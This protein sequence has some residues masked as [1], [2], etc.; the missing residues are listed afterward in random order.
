[1]L[2][3]GVH[4]PRRGPSD[5]EIKLVPQLDA[6]GLLRIFY[7]QWPIIGFLMGAGFVLG[8]VYT[9]LATPRYT[10]TVLLFVDPHKPQFNAKQ[11]VSVNGPSDPGLIESQ[12][13]ILKSDSVLKA[14]AH[15][16]DLAHDPAFHPPPGLMSSLISVVTNW[17]RQAPPLSL[18]EIE[19]EIAQQIGSGLKVKRVGLTYVIQID[20][21]STGRELSARIA[22][23]VAD[24]YSLAE[25]DAQYRSNRQ[26]SKWL[27]DRIKELRAQAAD[28]DRAVQKFKAEND[29]VDTA[30][31][32]LNEQQLADVNA[33]LVAAKAAT[34]EARAR[35][36]RVMEISR[37]G[38][39]D[40]S[41]ADALR[42]EVI[43]RLRAQYLDLSAKRGEL[44]R[45]YGRSHGAVA[46]IDYQ[47]EE[48]KRSIGLELRRIAE[49]N[50]S[51]YE[52]ARERE[53]SIRKSL[54]ELVTQAEANNQALVRLRDLESSAQTYR[55]LYDSF[56]QKFEEATQQQS[57]PVSS[58]RVITP[59][60]EPDR[61][62]WPRGII[63]M[64]GAL[65]LGL[66]L[67]IVASLLKEFLGNNFR[68]VDDVVHYAGV[69]CLGILPDLS[70]ERAK[71]KA[72]LSR[73]GLLGGASAYVRHSVD[74]PFSRF[75]ET[76]RNVKVSI[77]IARSQRKSGVVGVVSS[78][79]GEGKTTFAANL[80]LL[81][82][83]MGHRT[84]LIDGDLHNPS[85]T[86]TL[87]GGVNAGL[88]EVL[89]GSA[90]LE[91]VVVADGATGLIFLPSV[92][93][94]HE[95]NVVA[96]M[97]SQAMSDLLEASRRDYEYIIVDLP[98]AV[99]VVDVKA[100]AHL[101]DNF[102]FII[103]WGAT[104][105]DVVREALESA[106][107]LRQR[108]LGAVLNK[109]DPAELKRFE[110]YKGR[111]YHDYYVEG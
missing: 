53:E 14:A 87:A 29:L 106:D 73:P 65:A 20:Y 82:A 19:S 9:L 54:K 69:E 76:I 58:A 18:D 83:Q 66:A 2:Q 1:M 63:V 52:V 5:S 72:A 100:S 95:S 81:M 59:A 23:G 24:A 77:D 107:T 56:F 41:V 86:R 48:I 40:G 104:S 84:L 57:F 12:V 46:N 94:A 30:R 10:A 7:R 50:K 61:P 13:E 89:M 60:A 45:R 4:G 11:E 44:S 93:R 38:L 55:S 15:A 17:L 67:G 6:L 80:A 49:S 97:T 36:D 71:K 47:M 92:L 91:D 68:G 25:L 26:A 88:V 32:S 37:D 101:I 109:A 111:Y 110:A 28:A 85:L 98:P 42:S 35:F 21:T 96:L 90:R 78:V 8:A 64:P 79:P 39:A 99:P 103:Q 105:R 62:S 70:Y 31:G 75:T 43:T 51:D 108:V 22:N 16:L 74:A 3:I 33:Q 102:V 34:A 27:Q